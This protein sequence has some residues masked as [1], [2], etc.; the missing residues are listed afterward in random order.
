MCFTVYIASND[1]LP[2]VDTPNLHVR[3]ARGQ[4]LSVAPHFSKPHVHFI[5]AYT[6]CACGFQPPDGHDDEPRAE[7]L[8]ELLQF[9]GSHAP[10][11]ELELFVSWAGSEDWPA[12]LR[13]AFP[14]TELVSRVDWCSEQTFAA[15]AS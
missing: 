8:R 9:L 7:S 6:G 2:D 11:E 10:N 3:P 4:E 15:L 1:Q 5:G 14:R 13:L 12:Q